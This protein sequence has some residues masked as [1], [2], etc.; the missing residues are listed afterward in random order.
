MRTPDPAPEAAPRHPTI[1]PLMGISDMAQL[2]RVSRRTVERLLSAGRMPAPDIVIG[3]L[4]RWRAESI[5]GWIAAAGAR[6]T[7]QAAKE[8]LRA[9]LARRLRGREEVTR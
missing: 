3:R 5:R 4:P 1:E 6:H 9:D 8:A 2:L 7:L